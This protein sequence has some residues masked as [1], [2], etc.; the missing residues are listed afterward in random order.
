MELLNHLKEAF[1]SGR[2]FRP[3]LGGAAGVEDERRRH[4]RV[5]ARQGTRVLVIDDSS[6][7]R[8]ELANMFASAGYVTLQARDGEQGLLKACF[9][10]P[11]LVVLDVGMPGMNGFDVLRKIRKDPLARRIPVIMMSGNKQSLRQL[12]RADYGADAILRKPFSRFD[13]FSRI[14][15]MLDDELVPR[16]P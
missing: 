2:R 11:D 1:R 16:R 14:E 3:G 5:N 9:E 15:R 12:A 10:K 8:A 4:R 13:L 7:S 6:K